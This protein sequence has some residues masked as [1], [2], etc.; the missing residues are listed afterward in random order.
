VTG[1]PAPTYWTIVLHAE[2]RARAGFPDELF[3]DD[4][5]IWHRQHY[6]RSG[7]VAYATL[8]AR[9]DRLTVLNLV[10]DLV[11]RQQR[12]P[13]FRSRIQNRFGGW[14]HLLAN[15]ILCFAIQR[16]F[17]VLNLPR[18][19]LV[20]RHTDPARAPK[21]ALFQRVY[22]AA[23]RDHF[24]V[25]ARGDWW[26][27]DV[28]GNRDRAVPP[29]RETASAPAGRRIAI[30]H[31]T[32]R[33]LGH[34]DRDPAF[35]ARIDRPSAR[36]LDRMLKLERT[37]R[38]PATYSIVGLLFD[39]VAPRIQAEGHAL[40]FHSYDHGSAADQLRPCREI[41][42]R[43]RGYRPPRSILTPE[44]APARLRRFGFYW[45]A[46]GARSLGL[47]APAVRDQVAQIPIL[48][49]DFPLHTGRRTYAQWRDAAL[50]AVARHPIAVFGLHDCYAGHWIADYP[51]LLDD[52]AG[53]GAPRT[54]DQIA[55]GLF[56]QAAV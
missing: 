32:E 34:R 52:L 12:A 19:A 14:P 26:R 33:G 13:A 30:V 21:P 7:H 49:D 56:L 44:M 28:A 51:R 23:I 36:H 4:D 43:T 3:F 6:G 15:A 25:T 18:A 22:D 24:D 50:A 37:A 8:A 54:L 9:G 11:Q 17:R 46:S 5:L 55:D 2:G 1:G 42:F 45:L 40:C 29:R 41:D 27:L 10:S 31:D 53:L 48:F 35:A 16:G 38:W 47:A 39:A 20:L